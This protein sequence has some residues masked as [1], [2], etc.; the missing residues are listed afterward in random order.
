MEGPG[1]A[2]VFQLGQIH[3]ISFPARAR[4]I[5]LTGTDLDEVARKMHD[6]EKKT[7]KAASPM[8]HAR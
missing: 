2:G 7:D 4:L 8:A 6:L 5:R 3:S 1:D